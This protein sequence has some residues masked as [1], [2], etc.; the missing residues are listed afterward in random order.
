MRSRCAMCVNAGRGEKHQPTLSCASLF[1]L[2]NDRIGR[3]G[4]C[5]RFQEAPKVRGGGKK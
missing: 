5:A 1:T 4:D 3:Q 2:A